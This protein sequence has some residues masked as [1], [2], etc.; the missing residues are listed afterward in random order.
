ME[1]KL[2]IPGYDIQTVTIGYVEKARWVRFIYFLLWSSLVLLV[3][4]Y[5][6]KVK[7]EA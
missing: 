3:R 6:K 2:E 4:G 5:L 1:F 7:Y